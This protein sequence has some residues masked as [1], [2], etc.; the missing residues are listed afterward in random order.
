MLPAR[1]LQLVA[2]DSLRVVA[3]AVMTAEERR[4]LGAALV[5]DA[6]WTGPAGEAPAESGRSRDTEGETNPAKPARILPG[7]P[8]DYR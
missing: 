1:P 5:D 8:D 7:F 3:R 4:Q 6:L 2:P